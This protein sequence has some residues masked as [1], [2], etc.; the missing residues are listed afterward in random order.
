[1]I[2]SGIPLK[3]VSA[4]LGHSSVAITGDLYS[5]AIQSV[6]ALAAGALNDILSP[7]KNAEKNIKVG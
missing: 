7:S 6:D 1:M 3:T 4:R 2:A 5:H